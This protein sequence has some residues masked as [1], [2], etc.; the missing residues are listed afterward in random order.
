MAIVEVSAA[1]IAQMNIGTS[2]RKTKYPWYTT[3]KGE[4]FFI[5][6]TN[7]PCKYYRPPVPAPLKRQGQKW[8]GVKTTLAGIKEPGILMIRYE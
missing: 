7:A 4:G 3:E 1:E 6:L 2:P 5:T 8:R